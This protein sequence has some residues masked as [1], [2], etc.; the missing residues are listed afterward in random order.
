MIIM[1]YDALF[2]FIIL[3]S[4]SLNLILLNDI[5]FESK[6]H[7]SH[8]NFNFVPK[9][10][11]SFRKSFTILWYFNIISLISSIIYTCI[12]FWINNFDG[13]TIIDKSIQYIIVLIIIT[14]ITNIIIIIGITLLIYYSIKYISII[15]K[16]IKNLLFNFINNQPLM[17]NIINKYDIDYCWICD[18]KFNKH[19]IIK[20][21]SCPCNE[22]FHPECID[23]YLS[24]HKNYCR[25]GHKIAK[26][27]HT[28]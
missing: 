11:P 25:A 8:I 27:E 28:A 16:I 4:L 10:Y 24:I 6:N 14:T 21:L 5:Y 17:D 7:S 23:K 26:Y 1:D 3:N 15:N 18:K 12:S 9:F 22:Y 20:K 2:F 19:K 13:F